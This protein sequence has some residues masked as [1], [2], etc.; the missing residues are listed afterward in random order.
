[1]KIRIVNHYS[2]ASP[3]SSSPVACLEI[4]GSP[5]NVQK[6]IL[7]SSCLL[8]IFADSKDTGK[9]RAFLNSVDSELLA[10]PNQWFRQWFH[11]F[12][13]WIG[14]LQL[15]SLESIAVVSSEV[16]NDCCFLL[17]LHCFADDRP[18]LLALL[19]WSLD[20]WAWCLNGEVTSMQAAASLRERFLS[21]HRQPAK[22]SFVAMAKHL[23]NCGMCLDV[24]YRDG[25]YLLR[26]GIGA[27]FRHVS[28]KI[29]DLTSSWGLHITKN[30]LAT[31]QLLFNAGLPVASGGVVTGLA[32]ALD[33]STR[34]GYPV[35]LKPLAADQGIGVVTS[36]R[37][38]EEL[39]QAWK[40]ASQHG[41]LG[42]VE[43]H[44]PGKDFRFLVVNGKLIAALERIPGGVVGDGFSDVEA[45]IEQENQSRSANLVAVEGGAC[46]K[47][48][49][50]DWDD[51]AKAMLSR[52][53]LGIDFIPESGQYVRLRYSANFSVGGSVRECMGELHPFN[54]FLLEKAAAL[55]RLDI[56]GIDVIA[57]SM[58]T[59][60]PANGGVIC[61][62]N[63]MPGVLP[64][65]LAEPHRALMAELADL[66]LG[67]RVK[68]PVVAVIGSQADSFIEKLESAMLSV[69][70]GLMIASRHGLKQAGQLLRRVDASRLHV[71]RLA[72]Q[73]VSAKAYLLQ[74]DASD[75]TVNGLACSQ[76]D[77]LV[78]ADPHDD[79]L[80]ES[81]RSWLCSCAKQVIRLNSPP[82]HEFSD[83][84]S[85][86]L[87]SAARVL[88]QAGSPLH[89]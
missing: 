49:P 71:Q 88:A 76:L 79:F 4:A 20:A 82:G 19:N 9:I 46:L 30:K 36:I 70:P 57:P 23:A 67:Q 81:L 50:L 5:D 10:Q 84:A 39:G 45:L 37:D 17:A 38:G 60:L 33:V 65:M 77:L 16:E 35:V 13:R 24:Y 11:L 43:K 74:L 58:A 3:Y 21:L 66:L 86:A 8:P 31:K 53:G 14:L 2:G 64:H 61:E 41:D 47:L 51:E 56:V 83:A 75:L 7:N 25:D 87:V 54:V 62:L 80:P 27:A 42:L 12:L 26:A 89:G 78:L 72:F 1:M 22:A 40:I 28:Q 32:E 29:T 44:M 15:Q 73:D 68:V 85:L 18:R 34:L 48:M 63:G 55:S 52:Q 69:D 6:L 59:P